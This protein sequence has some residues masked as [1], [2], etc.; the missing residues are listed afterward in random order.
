MTM[1]MM[2]LITIAHANNQLKTSF[3]S[4]GGGRKDSN[5][6]SNQRRFFMSFRWG[7]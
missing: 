5:K 3:Q 1:K 2:V 6:D 4:I 7:E